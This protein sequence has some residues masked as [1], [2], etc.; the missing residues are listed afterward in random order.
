MNNIINFNNLSIFECIN[1]LPRDI[2]KYIYIFYWKLLWRNYIPLT[3]KIPSW[4]NYKNYIDKTIWK[5]RQKNIHFLD[6]IDP[7]ANYRRPCIV[8]IRGNGLLEP[9][10]SK[11]SMF[12]LKA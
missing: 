11:T 3:A 6:L 1:Y 12:N 5:A 2:Q 10:S 8:E 4:H 7:H 9:I